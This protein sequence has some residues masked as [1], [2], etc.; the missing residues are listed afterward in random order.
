MLYIF[1]KVK[2]V[3]LFR[4]INI[5]APVHELSKLFQTE[6]SKILK[7]KYKKKK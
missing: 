3:L 7:N 4:N 5:L 1:L 6:K 2:S